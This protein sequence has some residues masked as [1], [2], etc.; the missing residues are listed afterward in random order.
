LAKKITAYYKIEEVT[1]VIMLF[2]MAGKLSNNKKY[3]KKY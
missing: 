3:V 1:V 2:I